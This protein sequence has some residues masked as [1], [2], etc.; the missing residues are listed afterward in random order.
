MIFEQTTPGKDKFVR[1]I[2]FLL[3]LKQTFIIHPFFNLDKGEIEKFLIHFCTMLSFFQLGYFCSYKYYVIWYNVALI[4]LKK[5]ISY[6]YRL[7]M[8]QYAIKEILA[9]IPILI[10][11]SLLHLK[12]YG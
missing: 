12:W 5:L 7:V 9:L 8:L 1:R 3:K 11:V 2:C 6:V 10:F 4:M